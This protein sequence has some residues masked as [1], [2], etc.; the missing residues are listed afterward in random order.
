MHGQRE[1]GGVNFT[2]DKSAEGDE[3]GMRGN[4]LHKTVCVREKARE[5]GR[6]KERGRE[7]SIVQPGNENKAG[8]FSLRCNGSSCRGG[9][10]LEI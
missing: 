9:G 2:P 7:E 8:L 3:V 6:R 10:N 1:R 5:G 4:C